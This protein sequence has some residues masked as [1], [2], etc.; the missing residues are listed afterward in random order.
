MLCFLLVSN[1]PEV[2]FR[3]TVTPRSL[4]KMAAGKTLQTFSSVFFVHV[5]LPMCVAKCSDLNSL[6]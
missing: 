2:H 6:H 4:E 1:C 5:D 3:N